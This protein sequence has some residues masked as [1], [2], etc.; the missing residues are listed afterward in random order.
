[1][2]FIGILMALYSVS[3]DKATK[4][5]QAESEYVAAYHSHK[6]TGDGYIGPKKEF[7]TIKI[8]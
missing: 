4:K 1:M 3:V 8:R 5:D 7:I 6:K 2:A